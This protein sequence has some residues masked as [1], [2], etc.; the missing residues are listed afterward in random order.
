MYA[1]LLIPF[2]IVANLIKYNPFYMTFPAALPLMLVVECYCK[3]D[4]ILKK[5]RNHLKENISEK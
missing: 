3:A 2:G 4:K 1:K 5:K